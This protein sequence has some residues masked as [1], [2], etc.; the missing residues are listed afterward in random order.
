MPRLVASALLENLPPRA[1]LF[2]AGDND[3]YP[4]LVCAACSRRAARCHDRDDAAAWPRRGISRAEA[5][6]GLSI[7]SAPYS[8]VGRSADIAASARRIRRPIA[9][10]L[11]V[12]I[13]SG[14]A[15]AGRGLSPGSRRSRSQRPT[16]RSRVSGST[17]FELPQWRPA[18]I[19]SLAAG[20]RAPPRTRFMTTFCGCFPVPDFRSRNPLH[21]ST[22]FP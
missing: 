5:T 7:T 8:L 19:R 15:L 16:R 21:R 9:V 4:L 22:R 13:R 14:S 17:R 12:P 2:V 10:A 1:V 11:T 20:C 18:S 6:D 3:S